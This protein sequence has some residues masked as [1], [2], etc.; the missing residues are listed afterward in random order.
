M[1]EILFG[2]PQHDF[3]VGDRAICSLNNKEYEV[4]AADKFGNVWFK[5]IL[6][7]RKSGR[8]ERCRLEIMKKI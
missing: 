8:L 2:F 5:A 6:G 4:F 3:N 1:T 7:K